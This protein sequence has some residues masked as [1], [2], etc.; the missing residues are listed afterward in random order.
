MNTLSYKIWLDK[1]G[2]EPFLDFLKGVCIVFVVLTHCISPAMHKYSLF[3][4]W[5]DMAVPMF[6]L[7]QVFQTYKKGTLNVKFNMRKLLK[8]IVIPF[9]IAQL[10]AVMVLSFGEHPLMS[11]LKQFGDLGAGA[12]YPYIYVEL[13]VLL[14]MVSPLFNKVKNTGLI[15]FFFLVVSELIEL[16]CIYLTVGPE[17]YRFLFF[18]YTFLIFLGWLLVNDGIVLNPLTALLSVISGIFI[19]VFDGIIPLDFLGGG[20]SFVRCIL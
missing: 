5:G 14:W 11:T 20:K 7:V 17:V 18:R 3:C 10:I 6:L 4:L 19:L 9:L 16:F 2:Y 15:L 12:Y 1:S 8:R 13:A